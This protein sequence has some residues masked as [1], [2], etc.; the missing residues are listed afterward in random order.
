MAFCQRR[1]GRE[2]EVKMKQS[3]TPSH[4]GINGLL[5]AST[6]LTP[7]HVGMNPNTRGVGEEDIVVTPLR[8]HGKERHA[9][10][11]LALIQ[12]ISYT[13]LQRQS[14]DLL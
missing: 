7:S 14:N 11:L 5:R 3:Y 10:A 8:R 6:R 2:F 4:P 1:K 12:L 9:C 13:R